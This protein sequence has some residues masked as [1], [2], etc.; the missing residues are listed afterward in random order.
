MY[1]V[2]SMGIQ[3][4]VNLRGVEDVRI[5]NA[6]PPTYYG[7]DPAWLVIWRRHHYRWRAAKFRPMLGAK[8]L[9]AGR[10]L[11][12]ATSAVKRGLSFPVSSEGPHIQSPLTT[13][14]GMWRIYSNQDPH[15]SP[16]NHLL[17][18]TRGCGGPI[19]TQILT[20]YTILYLGS[21][22][23]TNIVR[24]DRSYYNPEICCGYEKGG[25]LRIP[26]E[27]FFYTALNFI[28]IIVLTQGSNFFLQF[29]SV[30]A[31]LLVF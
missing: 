17:R 18:H 10:D 24:T 25:G 14:K 4:T 3:V 1:I 12:R 23:N 29:R 13:H 11:Y 30:Y 21:F 7:V 31:F 20:G 9:W 27:H 8:G 15:G 19:L 26:C 5:M 16:F 28:I 2:W 6:T 22:A